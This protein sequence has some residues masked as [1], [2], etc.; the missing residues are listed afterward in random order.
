MSEQASPDPEELVKPIDTELEASEEAENES[1]EDADPMRRFLWFQAAP[2]WLVSMVVHVLILLVLGLVTIADP[3]KIVNVLSA[4]YSGEEGPE[5]EEFSIEEIDPGDIS[6]LEE[7]VVEPVDVAE[8]MEMVEPTPMDPMEIATVDFEVSDFAS[9]MAPA[10]LSLQTVSSLNVQAMSSRTSD[11]KKKLLREYG[12]NESSE[13]A[14]TEALKWL[15]RHQMPNGAWTFQHNLVCNGRCGDPG[16]ANRS[17]AFN[18]AT[19]MGLLP[20][21]GA[22]QTHKAGEFREVVFRGLRFLVQNGKPG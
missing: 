9:E 18:A 20:F 1:M 16:E 7:E 4:N 22:G 2:A 8:A 10:A 13:A 15:S 12:G 19:A 6:E 5:V 14:V 21:M 17:K 3:I 11:M